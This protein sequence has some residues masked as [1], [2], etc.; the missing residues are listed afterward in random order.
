MKNT[1]LNHLG[2]PPADQIGFVVK[3]LDAWVDRYQALFGPFTRMDGA[4]SAATFRGQEEDVQLDIAF[5]RSGDV[6][7]EFIE[8]TGGKSPHSEFIQSGKEGMHHIR[9]RV[10]DVDSWI[11]KL[12]PAGYIPYW[13]KQWSADTVFAYLEN[14]HDTLVIE[15]I[16]MPN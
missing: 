13:Y 14:S 6:E 16:Q 15:L 5:G 9:F 8:W 4:I 2:L 10:D 12:K 11:K 1:D 3:D 7:I